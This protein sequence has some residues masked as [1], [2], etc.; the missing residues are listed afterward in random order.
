[1]KILITGANR[2]IGLA[3]VQEY[4]TRGAQV[5]AACRNPE[6]AHALTD[7]HSKHGDQ[8]IILPL[9]VTDP[10]QIDHCFDRVR[11]HSASLDRLINNAGILRP[12]ESFRDITESALME[13]FAVNA[14]APLRL[15]QRFEDLLAGGIAPRI[16]NI[17]GPTPSIT[18][19]SRRN[20][21]IYMA[22]RYA[23]NALTKMVALE[24]IEKGIITAALW[25][26]YIRTD[27]NNMSPDAT[28]SETG[29]PL[30]VNVI[31]SLTAEHNGCCLLPDGKIYEW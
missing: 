31:E 15:I 2:G 21:Q 13:S 29:I 11:Q 1:M 6:Q 30:A 12:V 8:V 17:T 26:G 25:P 3:L 20:N 23:H 7:L 9:D 10:V 4:V 18:K 5:F 24:L 14:L 22:S 27:M 28:P 16:V 19:L